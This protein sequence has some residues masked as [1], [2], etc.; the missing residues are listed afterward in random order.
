VGNVVAAPLLELKGISKAF[1]AVVALRDV[2]LAVG[3]GEIHALVGDNGAGKSTLLK[4]IS[5]VFRPDHG[6]ILVAGV[7]VQIRGPQDARR[8]GIET[9]YQ[10]LALIE[11]LDVAANMYLGREVTYKSWFGRLLLNGRLM[12][13]EAKRHVEELHVNL[14]S[15]RT[16]VRFLSGGQRQ[17]VAICRATAW[18][19]Q[20]VIMDE[21]TAA[22]GTTEASKVLVLIETLRE[23]GVAVLLVSHNLFH[24]LDI[25]DRISVLRHARVA[26]TVS[27]QEVDV[28]QLTRLITGVGVQ[29]EGSELMTNGIEVLRTPEGTVM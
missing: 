6:Q 8:L 27:S 5:G 22:L 4:I 18:G 1:G 29:E 24:V 28:N 12:R 14:P 15:V 9:L 3:A 25:A 2:D 21:P 20:L 10:E 17:A 19:S 23:R 26:A 11:T 7:P 16:K 13:S